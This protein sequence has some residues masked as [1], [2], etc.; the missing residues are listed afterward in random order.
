MRLIVE[1]S[2]GTCAI[3]P[4]DRC[5]F[6][7]YVICVLIQWLCEGQHALFVCGGAWSVYYINL[8]AVCILSLWFLLIWSCVYLVMS[9][10]NW[11]CS[12]HT[13]WVHDCMV[14]Q[15]SFCVIDIGNHWLPK[16][17][18][19]CWCCRFLR[20]RTAPGGKDLWQNDTYCTAIPMSQ[21]VT[22]S[23]NKGTTLCLSPPLI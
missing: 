4:A 3:T 20:K 16:C 17:S 8:L 21:F 7:G 18:F 15:L 2:C 9:S 6:L 5:V 12:H 10:Y 19:N 14:L 22:K 11:F 23:N 1:S 13:I